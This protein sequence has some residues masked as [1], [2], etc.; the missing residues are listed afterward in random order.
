M[1][2]LKTI[3]QLQSRD[4]ALIHAAQDEG[5]CAHVPARALKA[6]L[7]HPEQRGIWLVSTTHNK[8]NKIKLPLISR[9]LTLVLLIFNHNFNKNVLHKI[10]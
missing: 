1:N 2:Y 10:P 4:S 7:V 9:W 8:N 5:A 6:V 3:F